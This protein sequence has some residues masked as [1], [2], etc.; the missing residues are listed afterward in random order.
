MDKEGNWLCSFENIC[1]VLGLNPYWI[2]MGLLRFPTFYPGTFRIS[3]GF[4]NRC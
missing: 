4:R 1:E 2:R 3:G